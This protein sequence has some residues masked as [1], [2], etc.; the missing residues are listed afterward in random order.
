MKRLVLALLVSSL[1]LLAQLDGFSKEQLLKYTAKNPFGRFPD[2]RPKIPQKYI[3]ALNT[4][5]SEMLWGPLRGAGF[6]NQ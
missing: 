3:D 1:P 4:A 6:H 5:S 2:G